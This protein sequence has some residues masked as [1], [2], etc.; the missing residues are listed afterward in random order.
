MSVENG[1]V[2]CNCQHCIRKRNE[3]G[4]IYCW[5]EI[6]DMKMSYAR[7]M[8]GWCRHWAQADDIMEWF[9]K[10]AKEVSE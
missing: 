1:K 5:C 6:E 2:C 9:K 7:V 3:D 4:D 10:W 8:T